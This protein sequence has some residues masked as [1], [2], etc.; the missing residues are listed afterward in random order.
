MD[1]IINPEKDSD[2]LSNLSGYYDN[3]INKFLMYFEQFLRNIYNHNISLKIGENVNIGSSIT[4]KKLSAHI[5]IN[6]KC[7]NVIFMKEIANNF[8]KY[9][10][11]NQYVND[12]DKKLFY[13]KRDDK[14]S[15]EPRFEC[16]IDSSVY[17]NFRLF[18]ILYSSKY[19][20][21][22]TPLIPYKDSSTHIKDHLILYHPSI[23]DS[24]AYTLTSC[25]KASE[26]ITDYTKI[27]KI[28]INT[29]KHS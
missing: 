6:I 3:L 25:D 22:G 12:N 17:S 27:G 4:S 9:L 7:P 23:H 24:I 2:I 21:N 13:Y 15:A 28:I 18:R 26:I 11:S 1:R 16:I 29:T 5:R 14:I 8:D 10:S 20:T 19:Q